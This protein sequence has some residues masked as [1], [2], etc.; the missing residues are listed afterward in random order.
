MQTNQGLDPRRLAGEPAED[1]LANDSEQGHWTICSLP[2][3]SPSLPE[4][5]S[6]P[7]SAAPPRNGIQIG[8]ATSELQSRYVISYAV[9]CLKKKKNHISKAETRLPK[10]NTHQFLN[11]DDN[12]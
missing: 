10:K 2:P 4:R 1:R 5:D 7:R 3:S 9:F 8:R 6:A 11:D 12:Q